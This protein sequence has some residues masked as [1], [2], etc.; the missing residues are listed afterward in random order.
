M[1]PSCKKKEKLGGY[2][3]RSIANPWEKTV[4][5]RDWHGSLSED[6]DEDES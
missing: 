5:L 4:P 1:T 3:V 6:T 2:Q